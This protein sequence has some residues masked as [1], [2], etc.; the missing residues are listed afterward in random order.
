M[1]QLATVY[2]KYKQ[3]V[4]TPTAWCRRPDVVDPKQK[5]AFMAA[6]FQ[7]DKSDFLSCSHCVLSYFDGIILVDGSAMFTMRVMG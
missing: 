7:G 2:Q 4:K 5:E 6:K 3:H 1:M